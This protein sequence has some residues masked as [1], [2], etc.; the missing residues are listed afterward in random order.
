MAVGKKYGKINWR[1]GADSQ[2]GKVFTDTKRALL[3]RAFLWYNVDK[4]HL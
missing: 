1:E 4:Y 3:V 2:K